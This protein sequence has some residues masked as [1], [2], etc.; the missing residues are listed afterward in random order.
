MN[1]SLPVGI[2]EVW[3]GENAAVIADIQVNPDFKNR[4]YCT[5]LVSRLLQNLFGVVFATYPLSNPFQG[6]CLELNGFNEFG[7]DHTYVTMRIQK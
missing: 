1:K 2:A 4:R 3:C 5:Y 7:R 6:K